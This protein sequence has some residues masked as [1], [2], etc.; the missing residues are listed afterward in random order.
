MEIRK[1]HALLRF[2][3]GGVPEKWSDDKYCKMVMEM[4]Y[5]FEYMGILNKT[6]GVK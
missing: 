2:H 3:Y 5:C 1:N 4:E 6:I